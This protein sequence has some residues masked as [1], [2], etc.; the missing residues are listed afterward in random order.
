MALVNARRFPLF[1]RHTRVIDNTLMTSDYR[2][3]ATAPRGS[4]GLLADELRALG[5]SGVQEN[6]GGAYFD[7]SL[8]AA[9]RACLWLRTANR[10]LL[11]LA[12]FAVPDPDAL[13]GEVTALPWEDHLTPMGTL[14]VDVAGSTPGL[15]HSQYAA[16]RVKD[17]IVDRFRARSGQRP[18]V[19]R[20]Q[21]NLRIN[22]HLYNERATLSLDLSGTSL[23]RRGYRQAEGSLAPLKE[24]LAAA[25]LLRAGWPSIAAAGGALV[26]PLCGSGTFLIEAALIA[27]DCAP[28]WR[29]NEWGFT[30]WLGHIPALWTRL[31]TEVEE[32]RV[33]GLA[34]IPRITGYD[35]DLGAI[36]TAL[37]VIDHAG[38]RGHI[39]IERSEL[40]ACMAPHAS[41]G[42]VVVNPPYGE[43]LGEATELV[44]LYARLGEILTRHFTGWEAA[45]LT[46]NLELAKRLGLRA[47]RMHPMDNGAIECRLLR[48]HLTPEWH[49]T[50]H[51][52]PQPAPSPTLAEIAE[53]GAQMFA[54]RLKKKRK[55]LGAW[56]E[57]EG[58]ACY[59]IYDA[60]MPE[61]ALAIDIYQGDR[62][63]V[64]CQEY[65]APATVDREK[66]ATRLAQALAVVPIVLEVPKEQV[67][68]KV[69][70]RQKGHGQYQRHSEEGRFHEVR[71]NGFTFLVNFTDHLDTG[72]FLDHRPTRALIRQLAQGK[73][74]L[75]L[76]A[77]TGTATVYAAAGGAI[78]TT[79][80]DLSSNYLGWARRNLARNGFFLP[81]RTHGA[82]VGG[83]RH[84]FIAADVL[85]WLTEA[86]TVQASA[87][88]ERRWTRRYGLIFLDP[89]T[90]SRSK[91]ME[92]VLDVQRDHT[93]LLLT[94][95]KLLEPDGVILFS[96]HYRRFQMDRAAL[97]RAGLAA[98]DITTQTIPPDFARNPH[99]H[100]CWRITKLP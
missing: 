13:Y 9:Y 67:L 98:E 63:W 64:H 80:V 25:I 90:F 89:P 79:S 66:A 19:D 28:G 40:A 81:N 11:S 32:R 76:Y 58:V 33:A 60:D 95:A 49:M 16:Q 72:L 70:R 93:S 46:S 38:L 15:T 65:E 85:S 26:D 10:I 83:N 29:R 54:N 77:Y 97:T 12:D 84:E 88:P 87:P 27:G 47:W 42:L 61:Y 52:V 22:L 43:R 62:R 14:A 48:F 68:L 21:P 96:T 20:E 59:R 57:R 99:I 24:N 53:P 36:R 75:N 91:R 3:F 71:E 92:G 2:F 55:E 41:N 23:H 86:T 7:G 1:R 45:I 78:A 50:A 6:P 31:C 73:R 34:H 39:H 8:E 74:F 69:R 51:S 4:V 44:G 100:Q 17:A 35:A 5:V 37:R 18:S 82:G 56:A 94:A 30:G